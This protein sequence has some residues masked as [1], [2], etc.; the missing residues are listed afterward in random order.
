MNNHTGRVICASLYR[1]RLESFRALRN[2]RAA[3][4]LNKFH[5]TCATGHCGRLLTRVSQVTLTVV[6]GTEYCMQLQRLLSSACHLI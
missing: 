1:W 5:A 4:L 3:Y 2:F 6:F